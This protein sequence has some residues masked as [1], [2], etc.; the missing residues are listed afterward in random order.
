M[1]RIIKI[2]AFLIITIISFNKAFAADI[3][4]IVIAPGKTTQSYSTVGSAV[5]VINNNDIKDSQYFFFNRRL[6]Q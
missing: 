6:K 1:L 5:S 3:P 4:I 2:T